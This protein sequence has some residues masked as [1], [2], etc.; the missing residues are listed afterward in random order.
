MSVQQVV[1]Q[2]TFSSIVQ[3]LFIINQ[4]TIESFGIRL[5]NIIDHC[6]DFIEN[7]V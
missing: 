6:G 3:L 7:N 1:Q 5:N 4:F 2:K